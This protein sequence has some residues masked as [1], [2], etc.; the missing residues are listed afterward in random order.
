MD[1]T[2]Q[3]QP[4]FVRAISLASLFLLMLALSPTGHSQTEAKQIP[5]IHVPFEI[6][7]AEIKRF[8]RPIDL[9]VGKRKLEYQEAVVLTLQIS[10]KNYEALPPSI[11]PFLYIGAK[12]YRIYSVQQAQAKDMLTLTFHIRD[13]QEVSD[14]SP[15][16]ITINHGEPIR[17][18][19]IFEKLKSPLLNKKSFV[20]KRK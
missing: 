11:A 20:D 14:K 13:W 1:R 16:M 4:F 15:M 7:S 5:L 19:K 17:N 2:D 8:E 3:L 18:P 12:E 10:K 9:S 6:I